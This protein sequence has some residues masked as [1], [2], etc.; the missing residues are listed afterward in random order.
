MM[1][2]NRTLDNA[3]GI[4]ILLV[5]AGHLFTKGTIP[6]MY[7]FAFH[8]PLFFI[9]SGYLM[10]VEKYTKFSKCIKASYQQLIKP[11]FAFCIIGFFISLPIIGGGYLLVSIR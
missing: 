3:K 9:I 5:I 11:Y 4:G 2:R 7:I 8:M 10:N 6:F 1:E